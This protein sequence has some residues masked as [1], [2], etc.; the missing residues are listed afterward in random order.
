M[1][2]AACLK[3]AALLCWFCTKNVIKVGIYWT[4]IHNIGNFWNKV[5][6][7]SIKYY[8]LY[9]LIICNIPKFTKMADC[10]FR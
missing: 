2:R 7:D 6:R 4:K 9:E 8:K 3:Q 5:L 1:L 10:P